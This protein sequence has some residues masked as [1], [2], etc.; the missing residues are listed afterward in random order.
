VFIE[1]RFVADQLPA[2][3]RSMLLTALNTYGRVPEITEEGDI[4]E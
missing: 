1:S 3:F 4:R 2:E